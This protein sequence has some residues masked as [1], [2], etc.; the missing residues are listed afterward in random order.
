[1][2]AYLVGHDK[3]DVSAM[4][5]CRELGIRYDTAWLMSHKLRH[6]L[7]ETDDLTLTNLTEVDEAFYGGRKQKGNRGR[8]QTGGKA[9]IVCAVEK[10]P[11]DGR[12]RYRASPSRATLLVARGSPYCR[13]RTLTPW[14]LHPHECASWHT[15]HLD[16][17][18]G[19]ARLG[20]LLP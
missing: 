5:T 4:F 11:V 8:G 9:M 14:Q 6:A 16:G 13:T 19:Y 10:R 17:F 15:D 7:T 2:A 18:K 3:R 12:K 1:M 20:R